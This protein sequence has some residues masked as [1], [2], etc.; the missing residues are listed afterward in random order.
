MGGLKQ[1]EVAD[2]PG[3]PY[4]RASRQFAPYICPSYLRI[5]FCPS[6]A[7]EHYAKKKVMT[8]LTERAGPAK[9]QQGNGSQRR[10]LG[11]ART[12]RIISYYSY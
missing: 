4:A 11:R 7:V 3:S 10:P 8:L 12:P 2:G 1:R 9:P 5:Y 6:T